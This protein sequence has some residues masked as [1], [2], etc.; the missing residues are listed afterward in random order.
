MRIT[1]NNI[2][3]GNILDY[4]GELWII[5]KNPEHIKPGKGVAYVQV[6]MKNLR[7]ANKVNQRFS[8]SE[9]LKKAFLEKKEMQFLYKEGTFLVF[10]DPRSFEQIMVDS[11][12]MK[13]KLIFLNE[14]MTVEIDFYEGYPLNIILAPNVILE[15]KQTDPVIKGAN[16]TFSYKPA[17]MTNGLKIMVPPYLVNGE[18]ILVKVED[19]SF[20]KRAE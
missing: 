8:S 18:K 15:I 14:G 17:L 7:T 5:I 12:I 9:V 10:M 3:S 20:I 2:K 6:E 19:S 16:I 13:D 11:K 4:K 1:A